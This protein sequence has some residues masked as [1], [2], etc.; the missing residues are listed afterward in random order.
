MR[1]A[2]FL[3]CYLERA[4]IGPPGPACVLLVAHLG[5][6]SASIADNSGT[7]RGQLSDVYLD[8][9][10][11]HSQIYES[12]PVSQVVP[13]F[14][15]VNYALAGESRDVTVQPNLAS[16]QDSP[17]TETLKLGGYTFSPYLA[18][19]LKHIGLGFSAESGVRTAKY[20]NE[21]NGS[22]SNVY[23]GTY[24]L[25]QSSM[26]FKSVGAF[27]YL[28]PFQ[29]LPKMLTLTTIIGGRSYNA[30]HKVSQDRWDSSSIVFGN[31][32][33]QTFHYNIN[34]YEGGINIGIQLMKSFVIIP[35]CNYRVTDASAPLLL[36]DSYQKD[37]GGGDQARPPGSIAG[38]LA[39]DV[40]LFWL[41]DP[42][43]QY[44]VDFA[45]HLGAF[46]VHLGDALG[47]VASTSKN[48]EQII[49]HTISLSVAFAHKAK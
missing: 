29:N 47:A 35:W 9:L 10:Q 15:T 11:S 40:D 43:L 49:D 37:H 38:N 18:V 44:G 36:A 22:Q 25:Q 23:Q 32:D 19:S 8:Y 41:A 28:I 2:Q 42:R 45:V 30:T 39:G 24:A 34:R 3:I 5:W 7:R 27:F 12:A 1:P 21:P 13:S 16:R 26:S 4:K 31:H 14:N 17:S 20:S 6:T 48:S 46:E 33:S